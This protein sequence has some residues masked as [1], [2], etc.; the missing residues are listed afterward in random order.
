MEA[1][2]SV[3][4][5]VPGGPN[6]YSYPTDGLPR[7]VRYTASEDLFLYLYGD[8]TVPGH[9]HPLL[10]VTFATETG[11]SFAYV[12]VADLQDGEH[13]NDYQKRLAK[14]K[15]NYPEKV[16]AV[17]QRSCGVTTAKNK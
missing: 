11:G 17:Y 6:V 14:I 1:P 10:P 16:V 13:T 5:G 15:D 4:I 8:E 12:P 3:K 2:T 9:E 7:R